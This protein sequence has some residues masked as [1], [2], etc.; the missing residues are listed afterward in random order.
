MGIAQHAGIGRAAGKV[1]VHK[2]VDHRIPEFFADIEHK[3]RKAM[4]YGGHAGIIKTI[5]VAAAGFFFGASA[6]CVVPCFH[7]N[8]HHFIA[9][10]VEHEGSNGTIN[11][12]AH[13]HQHFTFPAHGEKIDRQR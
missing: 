11:T 13:R 6:T 7:G 10:I 2:I 3:M 1:F 12:A 5:Q 9:F 8:A 4:L